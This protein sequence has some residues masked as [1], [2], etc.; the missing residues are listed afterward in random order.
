MID[1]PTSELIPINQ[2]M[3]IAPEASISEVL[4]KI[5]E[6]TNE[7][8]SKVKSLDDLLLFFNTVEK[9][10]GLAKIIL[11]LVLY[12]INENKKQ[13]LKDWGYD[14]L[15]EF[16]RYLGNYGIHNRQ[17]YNNYVKIGNIIHVPA[18]SAF[19]ESKI[20]YADLCKNFSKIKYMDI[21]QKNRNKSI[22]WNPNDLR[23]HF[24]EDNCRDFIKYVKDL[25]KQIDDCYEEQKRSRGLLTNQNSVIKHDRRRIKS[26]DLAETNEYDSKIRDFCRIIQEGGHIAF[27]PNMD[28]NTMQIYS[29]IVKKRYGKILY[30]K[31]QY[32]SQ[33]VNFCSYGSFYKALRDIIERKACSYEFVSVFN[34]TVRHSSPETIRRIIGENSM[35]V[36]ILTLL[37]AYFIHRI[38]TDKTIKTWIKER[39]YSSP[40]NFINKV[41]GLAD[42]NR[43]YLKTVGSNIEL[44]IEI[45]IEFSTPGVMDKL[46]QLHQAIQNHDN[47]SEIVRFFNCLSAHQFRCFAKN[48]NF[49]GSYNPPIKVKYYQIAKGIFDQYQELAKN[50]ETVSTF[51]CYSKV[52]LD[53]FANIVADTINKDRF[54]KLYPQAPWVDIGNIIIRTGSDIPTAHEIDELFKLP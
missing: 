28:N 33:S 50:H 24:L 11:G 49:S 21:L 9:N 52:E 53:L 16:I 51:T 54:Q 44:A 48:R 19:G 35:F 2:F 6:K 41:F 37:Q 40:T 34:P 3:K 25:Q 4:P 14:T 47:H 23:K 39:G 43:K 29:N 32:F 7:E 27:V 38:Y 15:N 8:F 30:E 13:L 1:P 20:S 45:G 31:N 18:L 17:T 10:K 22:P 12:N 26:N 5:I 46:R 42:S 36:N